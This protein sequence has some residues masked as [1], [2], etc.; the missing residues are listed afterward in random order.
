MDGP[1]ATSMEL[2]AGLWAYTDSTHL[3]R[4]NVCCLLLCLLM[5]LLQF[6]HLPA[7]HPLGLQR[8]CCALLGLGTHVLAAS[9]AAC[10][11]GLDP[12]LSCSLECF[13]GLSSR[14]L[15]FLVGRPELLPERL[16]LGCRCDRG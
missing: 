13:L 11:L 1:L 14:G 16:L 6:L 8:V 10:T 2:D 15:G 9:S 4:C 12:G 7:Q 5:S 3:L